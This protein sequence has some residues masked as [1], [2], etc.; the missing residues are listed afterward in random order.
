[1]VSSVP[2]RHFHDLPNTFVK[3]MIDSGIDLNGIVRIPLSRESSLY[4]PDIGDSSYNG[5]KEAAGMLPA[6]SS[7]ALLWILAD[8]YVP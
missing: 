4:C 3:H 6:T 1:M 7:R 5:E 2:V 8:R